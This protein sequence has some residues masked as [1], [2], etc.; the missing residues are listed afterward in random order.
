M[1]KQYDS[2][3][4]GNSYQSYEEMTAQEPEIKDHSLF[5]PILESKYGIG[6]A[7]IPYVSHVVGNP[8]YERQIA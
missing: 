8:D 2:K 5:M 7:A 4:S 6:V 1:H 3:L